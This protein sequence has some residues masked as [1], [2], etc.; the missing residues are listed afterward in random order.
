[1][2]RLITILVLGVAVLGIAGASAAPTS[3]QLEPR[4]GS[5]MAASSGPPVLVIRDEGLTF[6]N[7]APLVT[8]NQAQAGTSTQGT[9][10]VRNQGSQSYSYYASAAKAN[11]DDLLFGALELKILGIKDGQEAWRYQGRLSELSDQVMGTLVPNSEETL[12]FQVGLPAGSG[13]AYQGKS[14]AFAFNFSALVPGSSGP[15]PVQPPTG[16]VEPPPGPPLPPNPPPLGPIPP[17]PVPPG[18]SPAPPS[19]FIPGQGGGELLLLPPGTGGAIGGSTEGLRPSSG[20]DQGP[21][22]GDQTSSPGASVTQPPTEPSPAA[23][24]GWLAA[25]RDHLPLV[26]GGGVFLLL[27]VGLGIRAWQRRVSR[28]IPV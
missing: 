15:P 9:L 27:G 13:D 18:P 10:V 2:R 5:A 14:V 11:G 16:P 8:V 25:I 26:I 4:A 6:L 3:G 19:G 12:R 23:P 22:P 21:G 28:K 7:P 1:M 20:P 24:G 17:G